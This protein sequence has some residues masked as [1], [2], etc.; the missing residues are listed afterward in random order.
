MLRPLLSRSGPTKKAGGEDY[1]TFHSS[2]ANGTSFAAKRRR[3]V[4]RAQTSLVYSEAA[5]PDYF[6][7]N[8]FES[9]A[10]VVEMG[11][12][13]VRTDFTACLSLSRLILLSIIL[14]ELAR[15]KHAHALSSGCRKVFGVPRDDAMGGAGEGDFKKWFIRRVRQ[16]TP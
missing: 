4:R 8:G 7:K 13:S 11:G 10:E 14:E 5:S 9:S 15:R 1:S 12:K 6:T 16:P 3:S 2:A